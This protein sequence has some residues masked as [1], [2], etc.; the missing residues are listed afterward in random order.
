MPGPH[1][2]TASGE[3]RSNRVWYRRLAEEHLRDLFT[4]LAGHAS[5]PFVPLVEVLI[6]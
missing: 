3:R 6:H 1:G 5:P 2:E 4:D